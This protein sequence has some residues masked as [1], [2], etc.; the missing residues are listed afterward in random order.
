M[1]LYEIKYEVPTTG[2]AV[3]PRSMVTDDAE[4]AFTIAARC[5]RYGYEYRI[6]SF[7]ADEW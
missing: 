6:E 1:E 4:E 5:D 7:E 3:E 2:G